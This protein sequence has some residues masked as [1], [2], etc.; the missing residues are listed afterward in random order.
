MTREIAEL[1]AEKNGWSDVHGGPGEGGLFWRART[2]SGEVVEI[3]PPGYTESV[4]LCDMMAKGGADGW[5]RGYREALKTLGLAIRTP[6]VPIDDIFKIEWAGN[7]EDRGESG[8][9][10]NAP[11]PLDTK[12]GWPFGSLIVREGEDSVA[13][14]PDEVVSEA[15]AAVTEALLSSI[16]YDNVQIGW[17]TRI[18]DLGVDSLDFLEVVMEVED[19]LDINLD[20]DDLYPLPTVWEVVL[21]VARESMKSRRSN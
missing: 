3:E 18:E 17:D 21:F 6:V 19:S 1:L 10:M 7:Y 11:L 13:W 12:N 8:A 20:E 2:G 15:Y 16:P 14:I 4:D 5:N 9:P